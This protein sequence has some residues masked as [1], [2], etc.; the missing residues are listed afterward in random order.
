MKSVVLGATGTVGSNVVRELVARNQ[1]VRA[2]TRDRKKAQALGPNVEV[3]QGDITDP[4][5]LATLFDGVDGA[6]VLNPVSLSEASE[7]L[8][9]VCAARL[10]RVKRVVFMS[11]H[12][13]DKA[14]WLPHFGSKIGVE[15]G[16]R[17]SGMT[18]TILRPNSFFQNDARAKTALLEY[19]V[20][21][22]PLGSK[23]VSRVDVRDIAE[24]AA[25]ALTQDGHAGRTYSVVGPRPLTGTESAAVWAQTLGRPIRY[26]GD[27]LDAWEQQML[28]HAPAWMV[29]DLKHMYAHFQE[30]GLAGTAEDVATLTKLLGHAPRAFEDYAS[31]TAAEWTGQG[32]VKD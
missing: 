15:A 16:V 2:L 29:Y 13:V 8:L 25:I 31:E 32:A 12:E 27:D 19:G 5:T 23:G 22:Q 20:Y 10:A 6:F 3:V 24:A 14:P 28:Q 18:W 9:A 7:G 21:P 4:A 17:G 26:A 30:H 1:Q 11:V